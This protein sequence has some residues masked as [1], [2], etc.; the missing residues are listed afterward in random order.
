MSALS[1]LLSLELAKVN[2]VI[3]AQQAD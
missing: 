1:Y 3:S 2:L